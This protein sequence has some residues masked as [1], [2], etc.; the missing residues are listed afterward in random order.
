VQRPESSSPR[1][2]LDG[3]AI[4]GLTGRKKNVERRD[5]EEDGVEMQVVG[6]VLSKAVAKVHPVDKQDDRVGN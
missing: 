5:V 2:Y 3:E 1:E 4:G 6:E